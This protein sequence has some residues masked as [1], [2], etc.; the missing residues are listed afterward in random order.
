MPLICGSE[1]G[2]S[3]TPYGEWHYRELEVF[4]KDI[5]MTNLEAITCATKNASKSVKMEN[6]VGTLEEGMLADLLI[7]D[8]D[9]L[10]DITILGDKSKL[11]YIFQNGKEIKRDQE[12]KEITPPQGWRLSPFSDGILTQ[13]LAKK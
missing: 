4:V 13:E 10:K 12:S 9:P 8:G 11:S 7:V 5:G 3:I 6:K 1:S 2:F